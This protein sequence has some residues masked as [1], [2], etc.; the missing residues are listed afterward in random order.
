MLERIMCRWGHDVEA[1][2][3]LSSGL[4]HLARDGFD[5]IVSDI[6][7]PD[8]TGYALISEAR[9]SGS[10]AVAIAISA[11]PFPREVHESDVTGFD[12]HLSKPFSAGHLRRLLENR[13]VTEEEPPAIIGAPHLN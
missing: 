12:H 6:A 8:G 9:R 7:L 11:Y 10:H 4:T 3:D 2:A 1:A 13:D 5:A